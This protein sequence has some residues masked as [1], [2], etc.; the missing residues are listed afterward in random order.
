LQQ[1]SGLSRYVSDCTVTEILLKVA[2]NTITFLPPPPNPLI[3]H[4]RKQIMGLNKSLN[5][6]DVML[7]KFSEETI[8]KTILKS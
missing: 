1:V 4:R 5:Y 2:L 8:N 7:P 3:F 6:P